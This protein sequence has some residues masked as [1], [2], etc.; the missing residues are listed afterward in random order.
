M[1]YKQPVCDCGRNLHF[2]G[3]PFV[4]LTLKRDGRLSAQSPF[5]RPANI[6]SDNLKCRSCEIYFKC[7]FDDKDRAFRGEKL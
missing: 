2:V 4:V 1:A 5:I 6:P 3:H 7:H